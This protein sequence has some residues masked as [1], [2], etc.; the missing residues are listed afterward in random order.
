M[1]YLRLYQEAV[2]ITTEWISRE[3][4]IFWKLVKLRRPGQ[5]QELAYTLPRALEEEREYFPL[6]ILTVARLT[7]INSVFQERDNAGKSIPKG[8]ARPS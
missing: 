6:L 5:V 2:V 1:K 4:S 3:I 8:M 7:T